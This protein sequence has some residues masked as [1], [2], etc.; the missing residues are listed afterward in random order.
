MK[1]SFL[2]NLA[3]KIQDSR[4][5]TSVSEWVCE[6]TTLAGK[7]FSLYRHEFQKAILDDMHPNLSVMKISQVGLTELSLRKAIAFLARNNGTRCM[8]SFPTMLL[9]QN[10]SKTRLKPLISTDFPARP[11]DVRSSDVYQIGDSF[12][13]MA[14]CSEADATSNPVDA[15]FIDEIDLSDME[16]VSLLNS[17]L[18]H[19]QWKIRQRL[20]TPTFAQFG[21]DREFQDGDQ[22]QYIFRC[23]HCNHIFVP[24]YDLKHVYIPNLPKTVEDLVFDVDVGMAAG[25]DYE[26]SYVRCPKCLK[27]IDPG[28]PTGRE[29][30]AKYPERSTN[31]HSYQILPFS[32]GLLSIKYLVMTVAE[33]IS[34]NQARRVINTT[35]GQT[36][37]DSSTRLET[38]DIERC[39]VSPKKPEIGKDTPVFFG[40]DMGMGCHLTVVSSDGH[41][42]LWFE[43]VP[44]DKVEERI[45]E[46]LDNYNVIGGIMDRAPFIPTAYAIRDYSEGRAFP[47][48]YSQNNKRAVPYKEID[49]SVTYYNVDRTM[50]LDAVAEGI[51]SK[52]LKFF[53]YGEFHDTIVTQLRDMFRDDTPDTQ[54][55]WV[56]M[57][58]NDHFFH[59]LG[60]ALTAVYLKTMNDLMAETNPNTSL[61]FGGQEQKPVDCYDILS[62]NSNKRKLTRY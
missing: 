62:Y 47:C 8:Y 52:K 5:K 10:N 15:L 49:G 55:K 39:F 29:W 22:R 60:Y 50:S 21:I 19:S 6:N 23:P 9:K 18:Q 31:A 12:L 13:Y 46:L 33:G 25:L 43:V 53:G 56:K 42:V 45:K 20:S 32:S 58:G 14:S 17:R 35:L 26:N 54:P 44:Q 7:K 4:K 27:P 38:A 37:S 40:L 34:K 24:Q 16:I 51:R 57:S 61:F 1:N 48:V 59:S 2:G 41:E 28:D 36:Y 30:V 3:S 11:D